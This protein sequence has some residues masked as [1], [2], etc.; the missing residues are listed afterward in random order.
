MLL[1]SI[2]AINENI[3][4]CSK[5]LSGIISM[6]YVSMKYVRMNAATLLNGKN[7]INLCLRVSRV[8]WIFD[9]FFVD[10]GRDGVITFFHKNVLNCVRTYTQTH[11]N[12]SMKENEWNSCM[13]SE[14]RVY[15][16]KKL[17]RSDDEQIE[18]S[19][20]FFCCYFIHIFT[21][22]VKHPIHS[23]VN[24]DSLCVRVNVC[25]CVFVCKREL[26]FTL[27]QSA[28]SLSFL[29]SIGLNRIT[30]HFIITYWLGCFVTSK[31]YLK[32]LYVSTVADST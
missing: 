3:W 18:N 8:S 7:P 10:R 6:R 27:N 5:H 19:I 14:N 23:D 11:L 29:H 4:I 28:C 31:I 30:I 22:F 12:A 17:L 16:R 13:K 20:Y 24:T 25:V 1:R 32:L 26:N 21:F 15:G 2:N 9:V